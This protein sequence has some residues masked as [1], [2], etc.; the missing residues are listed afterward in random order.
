MKRTKRRAM[1]SKAKYEIYINLISIIMFIALCV[2]VSINIAMDTNDIKDDTKTNTNGNT[3]ELMASPYTVLPGE[4]QNEINLYN[5][6][7]DNEYERNIYY[8]ESRFDYNNL[9]LPTKEVNPSSGKAGLCGL[10]D[11]TDND[12]WS[13]DKLCEE[14]M[15]DRYGDWKTAWEFHEQNGW[16]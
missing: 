8:T 13:Q 7:V 5:Q 3:I 16:W 1:K 9:Y 2:F 11:S 10:Q 4:V 12:V 15:L 6:I 14:Y